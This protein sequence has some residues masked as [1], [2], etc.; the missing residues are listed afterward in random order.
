[1]NNTAKSNISKRIRYC[2][3]VSSESKWSFI[4]N[5]HIVHQKS[6]Q[7]MK[8]SESISFHVWVGTLNKI[9]I[10]VGYG[11]QKCVISELC[12]CCTQ[13]SCNPLEGEN[14]RYGWNKEIESFEIENIRNSC[15]FNSKAQMNNKCYSKKA[16]NGIFTWENDSSIATKVGTSDSQFHQI[17]LA[18]TKCRV[19]PAK[20]KQTFEGFFPFFVDINCV[21][22]YYNAVAMRT[23]V[24][25][26]P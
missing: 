1:M 5:M 11:V 14:K 2:V 21:H 10:I 3:S 23:M 4:F 17:P 19:S 22:L 6:Y 24:K 16:I 13:F 7:E 20:A 9:H 15:I 18:L 12:R 26:K 25:I 8:Y